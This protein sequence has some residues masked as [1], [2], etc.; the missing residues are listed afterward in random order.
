MALKLFL[1]EHDSEQARVLWNIWQ[2]RRATLVAPPLWGY[3]V[4]S[5]IRKKVHRGKLTP[6]VEEQL[7]RSLL[8]LPIQLLE[9]VGL[10]EHAW[11]LARHFNR[12]AAYDMHYVALAEILDCPFWTSDECLYSAVRQELSWIHC[13]GSHLESL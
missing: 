5:V 11:R 12:P 6:T 2:S 13:L 1:E 10:H 3:E 9:P 7:L 8:H 4:T